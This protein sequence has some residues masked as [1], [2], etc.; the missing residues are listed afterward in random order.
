MF[1]GYDQKVPRCVRIASIASAYTAANL[2][3]RA[4]ETS[5][6]SPKPNRV[7][8]GLVDGDVDLDA[9]LDVDVEDLAEDLGRGVEVDETPARGRERR[10]SP[11][12]AKTSDKAL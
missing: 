5:P 10:E 4:R 6:L 9:S 11:E 1:V 3:T 2:R 8:L 7:G 12:V